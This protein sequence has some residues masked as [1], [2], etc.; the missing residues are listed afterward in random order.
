MEGSVELA[1]KTIT[2]LAVNADNER[3]RLS[4][5]QDIL[6]RL[7]F[8]A[9]EKVEIDDRRKLNDD[10]YE[11]IRRVQSILS[12]VTIEEIPPIH[13]ADIEDDQRDPSESTGSD[14]DAL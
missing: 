2:F 8:K 13:I 3:V 11:A 9:P 1:S 4:A 7:G 14:N 5:A 10:D 6:D 12:G